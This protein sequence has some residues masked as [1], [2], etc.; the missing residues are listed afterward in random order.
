MALNILLD[1]GFWFALYDKRDQYH[2]DALLLSTYL[3]PHRL[4]IPWPSLYETLNTRFVRH[5]EWLVAFETIVKRPAVERLPDEPY[6]E[7]A[8]ESVFSKSQ[9]SLVDMIIREILMDVSIKIDAI[10]TFNPSDFR[11]ICAQRNIELLSD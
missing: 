8:L 1:T 11:D 3:E 2:D 7:K 6:R 10:L 4:I 9:Y 5:P